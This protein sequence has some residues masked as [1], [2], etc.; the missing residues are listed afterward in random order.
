VK[1]KRP[2]AFI[3]SG[4]PTGGKSVDFVAYAYVNMFLDSLLGYNLEMFPRPNDASAKQILE[5]VV[6]APLREGR[7]GK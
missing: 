4:T 1:L 2:S 6:M 7:Q 5:K 3:V